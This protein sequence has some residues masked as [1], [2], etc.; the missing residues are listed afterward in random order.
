M[1]HLFVVV[2]VFRL[3]W[4]NRPLSVGEENIALQI[5]RPVKNCRTEVPLC[6]KTYGERHRHRVVAMHAA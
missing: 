4:L 2:V 5:C 1:C 6:L 3:F